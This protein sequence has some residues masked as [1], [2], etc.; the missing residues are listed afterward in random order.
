M[1]RKKCKSYVAMDKREKYAERDRGGE[2]N[3]LNEATR[4]KQV[5]SV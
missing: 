1:G 3:G 2:R 5:I 4:I